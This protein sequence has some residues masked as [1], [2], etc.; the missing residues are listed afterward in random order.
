VGTNPFQTEKPWEVSEGTI[1]SKGDYVCTITKADPEGNSSGGHPQLE[2]TLEDDGGQGFITDWIV[3]IPSTIGKV[4]QLT[5]AAGVDRPEDD[6]VVPEGT[7]FR[8]S[9]SYAS[10]LVDKKV[11]VLVREEPNRQDPTK[12]PKDRVRGYVPA[13]QI[14]PTSDV[15]P[16]GAAAQ[17]SHSGAPSTNVDD[18]IPF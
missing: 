7:G 8:L 11:G 13:D 14:K 2:V 12:P 5:D 4:V 18:E 16:A 15:T 17:F 9:N 3:V 6:E 1:L 10:K